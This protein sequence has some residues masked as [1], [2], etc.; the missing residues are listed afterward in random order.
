M[1]RRVIQDDDIE[2]LLKQIDIHLS[3]KIRKH[4]PGAFV[5]NHEAFGAISEEYHELL[6]E[7]RANNSENFRTE[8][9]DLI[10][11]AMWG[12]LSNEGSNEE[13]NPA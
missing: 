2:Q 9:L 8:S 7:L 6:D 13:G 1:E 10:V 12:I 11:A 5:S 4:G 3:Y